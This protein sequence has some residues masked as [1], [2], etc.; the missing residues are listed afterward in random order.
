MPIPKLLIDSGN[1]RVKAI[2]GAAKTDFLHQIAPITKSQFDD[3]LNRYQDKQNDFLAVRTKVDERYEDFYYVVG[4]TALSYDAQ[5]RQGAT[6]YIRSYYGPLFAAT[7]A[8][9]SSTMGQRNTKGKFIE[10]QREGLRVVASHASRDHRFAGNLKDALNGDWEFRCGN[11]EYRFEAEVIDVYEEPFGGYAKRAFVK[12]AHGRWTTPLARQ[13]VGIIDI[14]GGTV[15]VLTVNGG[16]VDYASANSA[17]Q[18]VNLAI[19][20]LKDTLQ[21]MYPNLFVQAKDIPASVLQEAI[22]TGQYRGRGTSW[23]I[24][25]AVDE[26]LYPLLNE[27]KTLWS[28]SLSAGLALDLVLLTG[29][30]NVLLGKAVESI[31]DFPS[32]SVLYATDTPELMQFA[33]VEGAKQYFDLIEEI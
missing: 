6:R 5:R 19:T 28:E 31:L 22:R 32:E 20:R 12:N 21:S 13:R 16:A 24:S 18:G 10:L 23:D 7:V 4:D 29:G 2:A 26:A 15:G 8:R 33:N 9:L 14:G 27:V 3:G 30:G 11:D 1:H 17:G 25:D